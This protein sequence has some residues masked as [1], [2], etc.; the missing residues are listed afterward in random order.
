MASKLQSEVFSHW[1][2]L[3]EG[4]QASSQEFYDQ[5][6]QAIQKRQI[7]KG[8]LSRITYKEGGLLSA[9][10]EYLRVRCKELTFDVCAAP[11]GTGYFVSWWLG[12]LPSGCL[13]SLV[14][15][16]PVLG[17]LFSIFIKPLTYYKID[18][19]L[20]FQESVR[21][22]IMEVLDGMTTAKGARGLTELERKPIMKD[23]FK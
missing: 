22:A 14:N 7:P 21:L 1:Y 15:S 11:Y 13:T 8:E 2:H 19:A 16:I 17:P 12:Q 18:T 23:F 20:M 4:F 9:K 10:R 3:F 5:V 6:E